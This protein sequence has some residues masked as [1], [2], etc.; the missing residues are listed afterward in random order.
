MLTKQMIIPCLTL[1]TLKMRQIV[2]VNHVRPHGHR[3]PDLQ[4][5]FFQIKESLGK[6]QRKMKC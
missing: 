3:Q 6:F 1:V 2:K 5:D 4:K